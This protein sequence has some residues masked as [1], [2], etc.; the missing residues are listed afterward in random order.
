MSGR[1]LQV[2]LALVIV[3]ATA[4]L[5][6]GQQMAAA[7]PA[8]P[9][10]PPAP[11]S[12]SPCIGYVFGV[13]SAT[14]ASCCSQ[15]RG[16]L[17]AQAP[18]LCVA[19]TLAPSPIGLFLGQAQA[20]IPNVC[21]LPNPC[22]GT[23]CMI[24]AQTTV[25]PGTVHSPL[26]SFTSCHF[27]CDAA[28]AATGEG[29]TPPVAGTSPPSATTPAATTPSTEPSS[30]T[31]AADPVTSGAPPTPTEDA[32]ATAAAA[33]AG[34]GSKLPELLHAAGATRSRDMAA[35][36]VFVAVFLASLATMYV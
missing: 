26:T 3:T 29:S 34:N 35:G 9:S 7:F 22:D 28:E 16:F 30:G 18:C 11:L 12:L 14:L 5:S 33:P 15:L 31:P 6:S 10:C 17:Q 24:F 1:W 23:L 21:D 32:S 2:T 25:V 27:S 4:T 13:G 8:L 20:M 19:S 36:T